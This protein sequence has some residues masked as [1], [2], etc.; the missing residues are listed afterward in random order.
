M[1]ETV[2]PS[3]PWLTGWKLFWLSLVGILVAVVIGI[4][5][6]FNFDS[7]LRAIEARAKAMGVPTDWKE[8]PVPRSPPSQIAAWKKVESLSKSL[9]SWRRGSTT[10]P[11]EFELGVPL[12]P[13]LLAH[14]AAIDPEKLTDLLAAIDEAATQPLRLDAT[15]SFRS[16]LTDFV[17]SKRLLTLLGERIASAPTEQLPEEILE[18]EE[19]RFLSSQLATGSLKDIVKDATKRIEKKAIED[20]LTDLQGATA[21]LIGGGS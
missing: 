14:H 3:P 4:A 7:D 5:C 20:A 13:D 10:A 21:F 18:F 9:P 1:D 16:R 12:P 11:R 6:W 17:A 15:Y 19:E 2:A 8:F